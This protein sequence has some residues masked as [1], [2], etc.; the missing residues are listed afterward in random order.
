M[1]KGEDTLI[2][3]QIPQET[4]L[5]HEYP[6]NFDYCPLSEERVVRLLLLGRSR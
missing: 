2:K 4:A 3:G 6:P 1:M 5:N